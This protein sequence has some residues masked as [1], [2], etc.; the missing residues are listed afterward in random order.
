MCLPLRVALPGALLCVSLC[1][2]LYA[3]E[4]SDA[5]MQAL[6]EGDAL[7]SKRRYAQALEAFRKAVKFSHHTSAVAYLR[8]AEVELRQGLFSDS[9]DDAKRAEKA[10]GD[11]KKRAMEA[12]LLRAKVLTQMSSKPTDKKLQEAEKELHNALAL[13]PGEPI[14]HFSLG[15]VLIK[16][17]R[18][19]EGIPE[20]KACAESP[21]ASR[22]IVAEAERIIASPIRVREPFAPDFAFTT[23]E[24]Q[25]VKSNDLRGKVVLIDF[26]ATW[27]SVC[28]DS[29][30]MLRSLQKRYK[31]QAFVMVGVSSDNDEDA[32]RTFAQSHHMDW[33]EHVDLKGDTLR[34][35]NV[36][37]Y[38]T[39][40]LIDKDGVIRFRQS[41]VGP[42]TDSELDGA[43]ERA[44][45][46]PTN[47]TLAPAAPGGGGVKE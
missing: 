3:Q 41:G 29:I 43:I 24:R 33:P 38:P 12:H 20:M 15:Y 7:E 36:E 40:V 30:P 37:A 1:A 21:R 2:S 25:S 22:A 10:A 6:K 9:L 45:K 14:C 42:Y 8:M 32:V 13:D 31:S 11:D 46:R 4:P 16:E 34:T 28:R 5:V 35:F 17:G 47:S 18:D 26:W 27:C 23:I 44:L 39:F 19:A